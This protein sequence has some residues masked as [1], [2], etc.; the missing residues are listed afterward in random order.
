MIEFPDCFR[1]EKYNSKQNNC[2]VYNVIPRKIIEG[3][4][5]CKDK[6]IKNS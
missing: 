4:K 6:K 2:E 3:S 1:C 5:D